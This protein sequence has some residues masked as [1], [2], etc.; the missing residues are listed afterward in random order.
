MEAFRKRI[1]EIIEIGSNDDMPSRLYDLLGVLTIVINLAASFAY[2]FAG[3]REKY[4]SMLLGL[5]WITVLFFAADYILRIWTARFS[6]PAE[7]EYR[8]VAKYA[9]SFAGIT[10]L[11]SFLP[12]FLPI[13]FPSGAV[14][15]RMFR[16][17][18]ILRLFRI[19]AYYDS[20]NVISEV[21][22]S[23]STQLVSSVFIILM[24]IF[25]S[26]LCIYSL[27][28]NA[29]PEVFDNAFSG[30]YWA[31]V[32]LFT[33]GYGDIY[34]ITPMGQAFSI[35]ITFLGVGIVA[36]P[37][38]I[39]SAG[40]VEQYTRLK[41]ISESHYD[42]DIHFL[43]VMLEEKDP[44]IN[45]ELKEILFPENLMVA[46]VYRDEKVL[47]PENDLKL[48]TGDLVILCAEKSAKDVP[49]YLR[50]LRLR[51]KSSWVGKPIKD[52]DIPRKTLIL[53]VERGDEVLKPKGSLVLKEGDEI[54]L[55][56]RH[57]YKDSEQESI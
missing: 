14:V 25:A 54:L 2:T 8:S 21:L 51:E 40:F 6:F 27:E 22:I 57:R 3:I 49:V 18:R 33:V 37:T 43:K 46:A 13:F 32:T 5:E 23:K 44:W 15:F 12:Y 45:K 47:L 7:K 48:T 20:L 29:Q 52:L 19:N 53:V 55:Y 16:V 30:M 9:L 26:S 24:M 10:D 38:G 1:G 39:I 34:P 28:H 31:A 41:Q 4:G 11:L 56:S 50:R 36:I 17:I 42:E 35:A